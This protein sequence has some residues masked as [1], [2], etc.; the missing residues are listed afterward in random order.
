MSSWDELKKF[1]SAR[2]GLGRVG[3]SLKTINVLAFQRAHAA[4]RSAVWL[5]WDHLQ[6]KLM[7]EQIGENPITMKSE[8]SHREIYLRFPNYGRTLKKSIDVSLITESFDIVFI[9][10]DGLSAL[11][12]QNQFLGFWNKFFPIYKESFPE[13]K[14]KIILVPFGRVAVGDEIGELY[15]AKLSV[16]FIGERPGL[17]SPDSLG[18]YLTFNPIK[19]NNDSQRN[20]ISNVRDP[21]GLNF[22]IAANKLIY[23]MKE[24]FRLQLSGVNLKDEQI[25]NLIGP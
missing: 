7:L 4:A 3:S 11:A 24:S 17:N 22:Q 2:V 21:Q 8:A 12:I 16:I 9:I 25:K 23:L 14:Y 6:L 19:G 1:T 13:L 18:I 20:C 5:D 10:S 15:K